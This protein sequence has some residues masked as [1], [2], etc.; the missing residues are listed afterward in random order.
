[1]H[2][3]CADVCAVT[4]LTVVWAGLAGVALVRV[5]AWGAAL[6]TLPPVQEPLS[7]MLIYSTGGAVGRLISLAF[8]AGEMTWMTLVP[9]FKFAQGTVQNAAAI[10][11]NPCGRAACAVFLGWSSALGTRGFA[12]LAVAVLIDV[13]SVLADGPHLTHS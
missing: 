7:A 12:D 10:I 8:L 11:K 6:S 2:T 9:E 3:S 13:F 5:V 1:M 4:E